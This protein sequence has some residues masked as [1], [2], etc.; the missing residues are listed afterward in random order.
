LYRERRDVLLLMAAA[1]AAQ[2]VNFFALAAFTRLYGAAAI[3]SVS[4]VI[5]WATYIG[6]AATGRYELGVMLQPAE[7]GAARMTRLA[8]WLAGIVCSLV[9]VF[10]WL[11]SRFVEFDRLFLF[12]A[13]LAF[14]LCC[15]QAFNY[16]QTR[17]R[18]FGLL[19]LS[20]V[21]ETLMLAAVGLA[22]ANA[23]EFGLLL[24][25]AC[26]YAAVALMLGRG[27]LGELDRGVNGLV[28][29][30]LENKRYPLG[31]VPQSL[32]D[33]FFFTGILLFVSWQYGAAE[34]G[35]YA[36]CL[37]I[38][39]APVGLIVRP[40]ATV[41]YAN[42]SAL[43]R[44]ALDTKTLARR[45]MFSTLWFAVPFAVVV[46]VAAPYLFEL[47]FGEGWERAGLFAQ[48]I[49]LWLALDFVRAPLA[50]LTVVYARQRLQLLLSLLSAA[51]IVVVMALSV[52]LSLPVEHMLAAVTVTQVVYNL[53]VVWWMLNVGQ[54]KT[55]TA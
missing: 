46:A 2:V 12:C 33:A 7:Q 1:G 6:I 4:V 26:G 47:F 9:F 24:A 20:R 37:R 53:G 17:K 14:L 27:M 50:Q 19:A 51:A 40:I 5:A 11:F 18:R 48:I 39:Q 55:G 3:G 45:T 22:L 41:F 30:A 49:V 31:N 32:L 54:P 43:Y 15:G 52:A 25:Y 42:A 44:E 23:G 28:E 34:A 13:P 29:T 16:S 10:S 8:V 36:L 38:V 35:Y 21:V